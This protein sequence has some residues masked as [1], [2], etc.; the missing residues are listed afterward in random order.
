MCDCL[1]LTFSGQH[2]LKTRQI[3][4]S[5][6]IDHAY[7]GRSQAKILV[8]CLLHVVPNISVPEPLLLTGVI[9]PWTEWT[10]TTDNVSACFELPRYSRS[11][12]TL[13]WYGLRMDSSQSQ[14]VSPP[15]GGK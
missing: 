2:V 8:G 3:I 13:W 15:L 6:A 9:T 14:P 12:T 5:I 10:E 11:V 1:H 4:A 7:V